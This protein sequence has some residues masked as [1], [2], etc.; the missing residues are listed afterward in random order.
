MDAL[1]PYIQCLFELACSNMRFTTER[2][3]NPLFTRV[4]RL[5]KEA[6]RAPRLFRRVRTRKALHDLL[7]AKQRW[8]KGR[9]DMWNKLQEIER[10]K[11]ET[12]VE[13]RDVKTLWAH[14]SRIT[15]GFS[16]AKANISPDIWLK[17]FD[18]V[19]NVKVGRDREEWSRPN[20]SHKVIS[21]DAEI[22]SSEVRRALA[23]QK[24]GKAPGWDG[25]PIEF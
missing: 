7:M 6:K 22:D 5:K 1:F 12:A 13:T 24:N 3:K 2:K 19:Y 16:S 8:I 17:H 10:T 23:L 15:K 25:I 20:L 21:L 4:L 11:L 18:Q 9:K 14:I